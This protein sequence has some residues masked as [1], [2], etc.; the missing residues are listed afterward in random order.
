MSDP[1]IGQIDFLPWTWTQQ[2]YAYCNGQMLLPQQFQALMALIGNRFGGD[3]RTR[4]GVPDLRG[5]TM[6]GLGQR[7]GG[8]IQWSWGQ[9]Y[10]EE[11]VA[12]EPGQ[13]PVHSHSLTTPTTAAAAPNLAVPQDG[14]L[15]ASLSAPMF[16]ASPASGNNTTMNI[17]TLAPFDNGN[18]Q[19]FTSPHENRQPFLA[20]APFIALDGVFPTRS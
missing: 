1:Y 12:L 11:G 13:D 5:M 14:A 20:M 10:G 19:G 9:R 15:L 17:Q 8:S 3:G 16:V 7:P 18:P 6:A 2:G 4:F